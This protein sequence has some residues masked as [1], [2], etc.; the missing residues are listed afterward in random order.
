MKATATKHDPQPEAPLSLEAA[1]TALESLG[2]PTRLAVFRMLVRSGSNGRPVGTIQ[3]SLGI[4]PST[5][6]HHIG[7]LVSRG[8]VTQIREGRVLRCVANY[9][10]LA[11]LLAFLLAECCQDAGGCG[12]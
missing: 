10:Q 1:A 11:S 7:H 3:A 4:A 12:E 6:T 2:N 9:R 8:L 5:L